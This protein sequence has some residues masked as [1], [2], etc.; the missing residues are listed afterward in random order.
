MSA[1][2]FLQSPVL[3]ARMA[4]VAL[5]HRE[6]KRA[7]EAARRGEHCLDLADLSARGINWACSAY[8]NYSRWLELHPDEKAIPANF[9]FPEPLP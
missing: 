7:V 3:L 2:E 9:A 4:R 1:D 6:P 5:G 8:A